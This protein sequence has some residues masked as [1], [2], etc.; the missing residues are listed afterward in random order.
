VDNWATHPKTY[1]FKLLV[2]DEE[3]APVQGKEPAILPEQEAGWVSRQTLRGRCEENKNK[4]ILG[5]TNRLLSF[6]TTRTAQKTMS[7]TIHSYGGNVFTEP[8]P[9]NVTGDT[10]T[11]TQIFFR[12]ATYRID[13]DATN[14]FCTVGC[15]VGVLI[16]LWLLPFSYL[17]NEKEFFLDGLK[18]L[19]QRS[20]KCVELRGEYVE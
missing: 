2:E 17:H 14:N 4:K 15:Y 13:N 7:Q 11:D 19:E 10:Y 1:S 18:K 3:L 5:R 12:Y 9:S 6:D 8:L 20:H 16:N